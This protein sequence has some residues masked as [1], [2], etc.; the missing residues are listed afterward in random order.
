MR[1]SFENEVQ[2]SLRVELSCKAGYDTP[3]LAPAK[4]SRACLGVHTRDLYFEKINGK[5]LSVKL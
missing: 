3:K 4:V 1:P 2:R 5:Y